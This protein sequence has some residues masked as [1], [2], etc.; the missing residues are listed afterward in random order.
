[1]VLIARTPTTRLFAHAR[2]HTG[3]DPS[4]SMHEVSSRPAIEQNARRSGRD[5]CVSARRT[6]RWRE[7]RLR[8][9][10]RYAG[11]GRPATV[12]RRRSAGSPA[13]ILRHWPADEIHRHRNRASRAVATAPRRSSTCRSRKR[14]S[15]RRRRAGTICALP[16]TRAAPAAVVAREQRVSPGRTARTCAIER[17]V[18]ARRPFQAWQERIDSPPAGS[19][20]RR[21]G[22]AGRRRSCSRAKGSSAGRRAA[23]K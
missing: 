18:P 19:R 2:F 14:P 6:R 9:P 3:F 23:S 16:V 15:A 7:R 21:A 20:R 11:D 1:M 4:S 5:R 12:G 10:C 8:A 13:L 22:R 17:Q